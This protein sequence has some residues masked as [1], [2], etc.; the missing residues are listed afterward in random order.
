MHKTHIMLCTRSAILAVHIYLN[1]NIIVV[2]KHS[3][4][5]PYNVDRPTGDTT[6][7]KNAPRVIPH[8]FKQHALCDIMS[9]N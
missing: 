9:F 3:H 8:A 4:V 2:G 1:Y 6:I 5:L 7:K